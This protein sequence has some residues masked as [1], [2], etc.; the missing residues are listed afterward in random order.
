MSGEMGDVGESKETFLSDGDDEDESVDMAV[1][2]SDF[3]SGTTP[4]T[5]DG[6]E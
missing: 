4:W 5:G 1:L 3:Q 2:I 6:A